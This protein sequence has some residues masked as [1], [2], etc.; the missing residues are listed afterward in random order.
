[1]NRQN[2]ATR[3]C[4]RLTG[5]ALVLLCV[6][7]AARAQAW[8]FTQVY[9]FRLGFPASGNRLRDRRLHDRMKAE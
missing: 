4:Q 8:D 6:S 5:M 3:Q 2:A 7:A 1:M 9:D